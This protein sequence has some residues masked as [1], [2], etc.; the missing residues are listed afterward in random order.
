MG[1]LKQYDLATDSWITLA[2]GGVGGDGGSATGDYI[3]EDGWVAIDDALGYASATT[4][5]VTGDLTA[6]FQKGTKLKFTQTTTKYFYVISSTYGAPTT[7]VTIAGGTD[8]TLTNAA[9][10]TP[11]YSYIE[12]PQGFPDWFNWTPSITASGSMTITAS[13]IINAQFS[14]KGRTVF[15][16]L[17]VTLTLGGS[18]SNTVIFTAP[19]EMAGGASNGTAT[20]LGTGSIQGGYSYITA[21]TPDTI[22]IRQYNGGNFSTGAGRIFTAQIYYEM[23]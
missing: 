2:S 3:P 7:T 15:I 4:F 20:Y 12:N 17:R 16:D 8:Y 13:T 18:A 6:T 1:K 10:D 14:I 5:T 23:E 22:S 9:I 11:Y 19:V 21:A